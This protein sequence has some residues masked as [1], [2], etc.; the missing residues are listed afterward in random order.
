[1]AEI[2]QWDLRVVLSFFGK[3]G[4]NLLKGTKEELNY[5]FS[6]IVK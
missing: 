3:C 1:M 2:G 5:K 6:F 4:D